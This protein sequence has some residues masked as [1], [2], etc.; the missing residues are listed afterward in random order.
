MSPEQ[1]AASPQL[2]GRTDPP[3]LHGHSLDH[4]RAVPDGGHPQR[5]GARR[6]RQEREDTVATGH[7]SPYPKQVDPDRVWCDAVALVQHTKAQRWA[8]ALALYRGELL[9]GLFPEGVAQ[10]FEEWLADKRKTLR[11]QAARAAWE[12]SRIE[13]GRGD[14]KAAAVMARRALIRGSQRPRRVSPRS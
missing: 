12:G 1:A 11:D 2:D 10:E 8:E 4:D 3:E 6:Q 5:V 14:R 7:G 13:E 9:E